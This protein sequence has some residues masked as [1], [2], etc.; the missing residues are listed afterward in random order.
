MSTRARYIRGGIRAVE[1]S[2]WIPFLVQMVHMAAV[3]GSTAAKCHCYH[4]HGH[5]CMMLFV[6]LRFAPL[7]PTDNVFGLGWYQDVG[8]TVGYSIRP[9]D[10]ISAGPMW[11]VRS[12]SPA[13]R[14]KRILPRMHF[15][16]HADDSGI[17][18]MYCFESPAELYL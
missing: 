7:Y 3:A 12:F 15:S 6:T 5:A 2:I 11:F 1:Q 8:F 9:L 4:A 18:A 13:Q 17:I 16:G 10:R 14:P